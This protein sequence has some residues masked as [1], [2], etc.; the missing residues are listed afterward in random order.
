MIV[1]ASYYRK[2]IDFGF[3]LLS[4]KNNFSDRDI[5]FTSSRIGLSCRK[6]ENVRINEL[7]GLTPFIALL[8]YN[9]VF[10]Y[11]VVLK[12]SRNNIVYFNPCNGRIK[13]AYSKF[14]EKWN[15]V[16]YL[17]TDQIGIVN[18][19]SLLFSL[20][21][22]LVSDHATTIGMT[23]LSSFILVVLGLLGAFYY[24]I[25]IDYVLYSGLL[26]TLHCLSIG[27]ILV[28]IFSNFLTYVRSIF[29]LHITKK[30]DVS[31]V[32]LFF[33]HILDLPISVFNKYKTGEIL[34]RLDDIQRIRTVIADAAVTV[35][36][37]IILV[38]SIGFV[39]FFQSTSLFLISFITALLSTLIVLFFK[40]MYSGL[41]KKLLAENSIARSFVIEIITGMKTLKS[42]NAERS[43]FSFFE[44]KQ[45][46]SVLS[47]YKLTIIQA[48]QN[49][50]ISL[51]D[52]IGG[53]LLFWVGGVLII[54]DKLS[55]GELIAY[56]S[57]LALFIGPFKRILSLQPKV[58][59]A[60]IASRR[61]EEI[62]KI[63]NN[64]EFVV[65]DSCVVPIIGDIKFEGVS[66]SYVA[67]SNVLSDLSLTINHGQKVAIVGKSGSGKT[68]LVH[69]LLKYYA[70]Y[71]GKIMVDGQDLCTINTKH[72]RKYIGYVPQEIT[73]FSG[74]VFENIAGFRDS[75]SNDEII[76]ASKQAGAH[77]FIMKLQNGYNTLISE[78]GTMLSGGQ[79]QRI[80]LARALLGNPSI[81][82]F[83]EATAG[84]DPI[85]ERH[86]LNTLNELKKK[87]KTIIII[88]H[89]LSAIADSDKIFVLE[90]GNLIE[91]GNH[92]G[93]LKEKGAYY[94]LW[95]NVVL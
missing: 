87:N 66:F 32:F 52:G 5:S 23:I 40:G 54:G 48:L 56:N 84:L 70:S 79:R 7:S 46:R 78:R 25:L 37:D 10:V 89:N 57:L 55:V 62:L 36:M 68:T 19:S 33:K 69:L 27:I 11:V 75:Y 59:E 22:K 18:N 49:L 72:L 85:S 38:F 88:A 1:I 60:I 58:Q 2:E 26:T 44:D 50:L 24:N 51:T 91:Q 64:F 81:I 94:E 45:L 80:A 76:D 21:R 65:Q 77:D 73:I 28:T 20:M 12:I 34:S 9:N 31:M 47:S 30:V 13:E 43:V 3:E 39:L 53:N 90:C 41:Y 74:S 86:V 71:S 63:P 35:F 93:L 15:N 82:I 95:N 6:I 14:L 8:E 67:E 4:S 16:A 17:F 61:V 42:L 29:V 83:D 92:S